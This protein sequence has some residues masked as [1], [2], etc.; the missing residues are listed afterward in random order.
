MTAWM[1]GYHAWQTETLRYRTAPQVVPA[2][3]PGCLDR[4]LYT[5]H[6]DQPVPKPH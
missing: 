1:S 6:P 2:T 5:R 4:I 3:G